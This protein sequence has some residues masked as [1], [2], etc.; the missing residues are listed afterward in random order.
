MKE[1]RSA[2]AFIGTGI[3]GGS[4]AGHLLEAGY[5]LHLHTRTKAR[6]EPLLA[7]GAIWHESVATLTPCCDVICTMVGYPADVEEI[8]F[9]PDGLLQSLR[10]GTLLIDFTTSHPALAV[11]IAEAATARQAAALDAPV[12][13]GDRGARE[14]TLSIMVGGSQTAFSAALPL[15]K[16][17]GREIIRQGEAGSGQ[18]CKMCNQIAIAGNMLGVCE[19]LTYARR[20]GLDPATVLTSI[21]QGA[22]GSWSLSNL[23]P[24]ILQGDLAP[25]F[26]IKHFIKDLGI[27]LDVART[28][29]LDLPAL[30]LATRLY[31]ELAAE[32][33]ND[34]GT[35]ALIMRYNS[36]A[37][38]KKH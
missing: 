33:Y 35:Q 24:R 14:A 29:Q 25:G 17:V 36:F 16:V 27:A 22:A 7:R 6:A 4:M 21:E 34:H 20:S 12:S 15:L 26:Y 3:M 23:G 11:R 1:K 32:G 38:E 31:R 9:G 19:A 8:Y 5:Q 10:P 18:H 28:M 13:G 30:A 2:I 37:L